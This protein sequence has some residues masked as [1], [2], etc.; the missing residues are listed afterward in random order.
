MFYVFILL[1]VLI[2]IFGFL[3]WKRSRLSHQFF[4]RAS[5]IAPYRFHHLD[6]EGVE[7]STS[8]NGALLFMVT[9]TDSDIRN[10]VIKNV[11]L[12]HSCIHISL[13]QL[14]MITFPADS[15][16]AYEASVRFR[17]R[18]QVRD[19]IFMDQRHAIISGYITSESSGRIPYRIQVPI[20]QYVK[21]SSIVR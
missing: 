18:G 2:F 12:N 21:E 7:Y 19:S 20:T 13:D 6:S 3:Y 8:K 16:Q 9:R 10:I 4:D 1:V 15:N 11:E 5:M 14:I 17:I